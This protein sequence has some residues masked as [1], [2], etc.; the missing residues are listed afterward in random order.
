MDEK[1]LE[2]FPLLVRLSDGLHPDFSTTSFSDPNQAGDLRIYDKQGKPLMHQ[3]D[4]W[5]DFRYRRKNDLGKSGY[6]D[7]RPQGFR[8]LG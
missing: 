7:S 1:G 8:I 3:V 4:R 2:N 5:I 6:A